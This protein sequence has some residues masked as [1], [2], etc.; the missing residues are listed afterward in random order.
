MLERELIE[1][2]KRGDREAAEDLCRAHWRAIYRLLYARLGNRTEAEDLT[3]ETFARLWRALAAFTGEDIGP[4][5]RTIALNLMR[6]HLRDAARRA[7]VDWAQGDAS[8]PSAEHEA[9][10]ILGREE[11]EALLRDLYPDQAEVLR[12]RLI[13]SLSVAESARRMGRTAEAVRSLQ[14]RAL[15][16]LRGHFAA[17]SGRGEGVR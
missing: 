2:A 9:M 10:A 5:V 12:L 16:E 1:R 3:Q 4:Y 7:A 17:R 13:E 6:N 15:Q 11:I 14:Y 8:A